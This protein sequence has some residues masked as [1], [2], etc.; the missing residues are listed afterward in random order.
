METQFWTEVLQTPGLTTWMRI[1]ML[2][3]ILLAI[4]AFTRLLYGGFSDLTEVAGSRYANARERWDA[5]VQYPGRLF[6]LIVAS[7][8]GAGGFS[9][10]LFFQG[11]VAIYFYQQV[12]A[13]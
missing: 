2:V 10:A 1:M 3:F 12:F 13:N 11:A 6:G 4:Y 9:I 5:R 7:I 8:I